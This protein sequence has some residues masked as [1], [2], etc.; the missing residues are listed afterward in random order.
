MRHNRRGV[1]AFGIVLLI[2]SG[3]IFLLP[4][5]VFW[6]PDE[7]NRL[8]IAQSVTQS[9]PHAYNLVYPGAAID[10]EFDFFPNV[11][12]SFH[13]QYPALRPDGSV[14]YPWSQVFP[15]AAGNLFHVFGSIGLYMIPWA[16]GLGIIF[17]GWRISNQLDPDLSF[18]S[19]PLIGLATPICFYSFTFWD[20]TPTVFMGLVA[21]WVFTHKSLP[22]FARGVLGLVFIGISILLRIEMAIFGVVAGLGYL[23]TLV[24]LRTPS[25]QKSGGESGANKSKNPFLANRWLSVAA[26]VFIMIVFSISI[27]VLLPERYYYE[28]TVFKDTLAKRGLASSLV[29]Y[30]QGMIKNLPGLMINFQGEDGPPLD[31]NLSLLGL[32]AVLGVFCAPWI[33]NRRAELFCLVTGLA[34]LL[35]LGFAA[36]FS[37]NPYRSIHSVFLVS[38]FIAIASYTLQHAWQSKNVPLF[39]L[40]L[41]GWTYLIVGTSAVLILRSDKNGYWPGLEWGPR[42]LLMLYPVLAILALQGIGI[43]WRSTRPRWSRIVFLSLATLSIG[44][45]VNLQARGLQM[46]YENKVVIS[47][48]QS[49]LSERNSSPVVT[50]VWWLP[51]SLANYFTTHELYSVSSEQNFLRWLRMASGKGVT[52]FTLVSGSVWDTNRLNTGLIQLTQLQSTP[53]HGLFFTQ[54]R[55]DTHAPH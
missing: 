45:G 21:L 32:A 43:F 37:T 28:L 18:W 49:F 22:G 7:G 31:G 11:F 53:F 33:K 52:K 24:F 26:I 55:L 29:N 4:K 47:S 20:H 2:Y 10:P 51:A 38:P 35:G 44:I 9:D 16:S 13:I 36:V 30:G 15:W 17:L 6:S 39:Y 40:S 54:Y 1:I 3:F 5:D 19:I 48:W 46:L 8:I 23:L 14:N 25:T 41:V 34:V 12:N 50:D 42:Y 27:A